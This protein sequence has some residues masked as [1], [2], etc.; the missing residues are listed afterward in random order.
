MGWLMIVGSFDSLCIKY[1]GSPI[2]IL[3]AMTL[4][5][6]LSLALYP[7]PIRT[8]S[9][10]TVRQ[11]TRT[12][13]NISHTHT[14]AFQSATNFQEFWILEEQK[15][16]QAN[17]LAGPLICFIKSKKGNVISCIVYGKRCQLK[18]KWKKLSDL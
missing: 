14:S 11:V 13:L 3:Y 17:V 8:Q 15:N 16:N 4:L 12:I 18:I 9:R 10:Y 1:E 6:T 2:N 7:I 5:C